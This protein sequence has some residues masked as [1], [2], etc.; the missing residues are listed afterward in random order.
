MRNKFFNLLGAALIA[1]SA[2]A[3][4]IAFAQA[5]LGITPCVQ[6]GANGQST[7]TMTPTTSSS[8]VQFNSCGSTLIVYNTTSEEVFYALGNSSVVAT[9]GSLS[10]PGGYFVVLNIGSQGTY[11]AA[12]VGANT[13]ILRFTQGRASS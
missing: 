13:T 4:G 12:I 8:R 6:S 9:T 11:F 7:R 1:L 3:P 5:S 2:F 10:I